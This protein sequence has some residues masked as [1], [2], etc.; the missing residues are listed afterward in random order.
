MVRWGILGCGSIATHAIAPAIG[1]SRNGTLA[2]VASRDSG[3]AEARRAR[4]GAARAHGTYEALLRDPNVDAIYIGLPNGLHASWAI[5]AAEAGKHVLC[6]KSLAL[7]AGDALRVASAFRQRGLRLVEAFMYRH[8]PQW[9]VV[10]GL[11]SSGAIGELRTVR[12]GLGGFIDASD[13]RWS[14]DLGGGALFDVTCYGL[15]AIR[16]LVGSEP[17]EV[18]AVRAMRRAVDEESCVSLAFAGGVLASAWGSLRSAP[19]QFVTVTGSVG[20]LEIEKPFVPGWSTVHLRV[21]REGDDRTIA[22]PGANHYLHMVEHFAALVLD[23]SR[24]SFPAED[25]EANV[26]LCDAARR[27]G[28]E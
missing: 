24:T 9:D 11:L 17:L 28:T 8:H 16:F 27:A 3:T 14:A 15:D 10:R 26:A 5:A 7:D 13:H 21:V 20:R 25:G 22:V 1:W 12:A 18:V 19:E 2:A 23:P 4:I 6:E